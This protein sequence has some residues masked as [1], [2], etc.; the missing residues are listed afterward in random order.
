MILVSDEKKIKIPAKWELDF[1]YSNKDI[2][3]VKHNIK[4]EDLQKLS[5]EAENGTIKCFRECY[6]VGEYGNCYLILY[7]DEKPDFTYDIIIEDKERKAMYVITHL[8]ALT[9]GE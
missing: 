7:F 8:F 3:S 4:I 9:L 2:I 1:E 5:S 6:N